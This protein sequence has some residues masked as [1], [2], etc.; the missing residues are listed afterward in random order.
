MFT[1]H[2]LQP[3]AN[4]CMVLERKMFFT[5]TSSKSNDGQTIKTRYSNRA[6]H[7]HQIYF[8]LLLL[9][10]QRDAFIQDLS[11]FCTSAVLFLWIYSVHIANVHSK[12]LKNSYFILLCD[13]YMMQ[14]GHNDFI[15]LSRAPFKY[16][17]RRQ[18][19]A[20]CY[21]RTSLMQQYFKIIHQSL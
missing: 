9:L 8:R 13:A 5:E 11:P 16:R 20:K 10:A 3:V 17:P 19:M 6:C 1:R 21:T 18:L 4:R 2:L 12:Q 7:S 15:K 14:Y